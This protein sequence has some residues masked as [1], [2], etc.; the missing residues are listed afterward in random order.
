MKRPEDDNI[1][2]FFR[3]H[4]R[5]VN[6]GSFES[7][8]D[9]LINDD[10]IHLIMRN[11][12]PVAIVAILVV[13]VGAAVVGTHLLNDD[14]ERSIDYVLDGGIL[15]DDAPTKY[16]EGT[17]VELPA[18]IKEG[19]VFDG[20][21]TDEGLKENIASITSDTRGNLTLY[22]AWLQGTEYTIAYNLDGG[23]ISDD[24]EYTYVSGHETDLPDAEKDGCDFGGWYLDEALQQPL[25]VIDPNTSGDLVL[26]A[27][28]VDSDHTGTAYVW[29]VSGSYGFLQSYSISGTLEQKNIVMRDGETYY[30]T[31]RNITYAGPGTETVDDSTTGSWTGDNLVTIYYLRNETV[32]GYSCTVWTDND[33]STYWLYHMD[34]QVR[35]QY[36]SGNYNVAYSLSDVYQFEPETTFEPDVTASYPLKV[37][38]T[39]EFTIGDDVTLTAE[40]EGFTAWYVDSKEYSTDRTVTIERMDPT[41]SVEARTGTPYIVMDDGDSLSDYGFG[42]ATVTDSDGNEVSSDLSRLD[43]GLYKATIESGESKECLMFLKDASKTFSQTWTYSEKSYSISVDLKYS[44]MYSYV[45]NHPYSVRTS[46]DDATYL[47]T[48]HTVDDPC[49]QKIVSDL[50]G[51][52][53][54]LSEYEYA[55]F[56]L[57]FVQSIPYLDDQTIYGQAEYWAYP[58]EYLWNSGGDCEDSTIFY[59][60]L[61]LISGYK[62]ALMVFSNHAMSAVSVE[63]ASGLCVTG[64]G[65]SYYFC[66]T[67][68]TGYDI[69]ESFNNRYVPD[70]VLY[71]HPIVK[72][73]A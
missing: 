31:E 69:G 32:D 73:A 45:Y 3:V 68:S 2:Q 56:V 9:T 20:W 14:G 36:Q 28:W 40:G 16:K 72:D 46:M 48:Y 65:V 50:K 38:G 58:L 59:D 42:S 44:D 29:D 30:T 17:I 63:G 54:G 10:G 33:G 12:W 18:P 66:E 34:L 49:L 51:M 67:T 27:C 11:T 64:D 41:M 71:W 37:S 60:T 22:A 26:Y 21:F 61:M 35:I 53:E 7:R 62:A 55:S 70:T 25:V 8:S 6:F 43:P 1:K 15:P 4:G 57:T 19:Y 5:N 39:G 13:I 23:T 24:A 52:S 47:A